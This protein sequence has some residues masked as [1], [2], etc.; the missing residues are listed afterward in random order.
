MIACA[1]QLD[2][3]FDERCDIWSLGITAIELADGQAPLGHLHSNKVLF[4]IPRRPPPTVQ[5]VSQW[6]EGFVRFIAACLVKDYEHRPRAEQLLSQQSFVTFDAFTHGRYRDLLRTCHER[7]LAL[8]LPN[9]FV[10]SD[11][12]T[13]INEDDAMNK[14]PW[15]ANISKSA[16][17]IDKENNLA[18]LTDLNQQSLIDSIRRRFNQALIYTY[19]GDVLLAINPKQFL[20]IDNFNFQLKYSRARRDLLPHI[21]AVATTVYNQM[22][23]NRQAQCIILSGESGSGEIEWPEEKEMKSRKRF[24]LGKTHAAQNLISE[25]ALLGFGEQRALEN[26]LVTMNYLLEAFG[27]AQTVLNPNSSRFGKLL[28]IFF[29]EYGTIVYVQLSEFLLEK[30]RVVLANGNRR[31]FHILYS[32]HAHF[33]QNQTNPCPALLGH[34]AFDLLRTVPTYTYLG[35]HHDPVVSC[36]PLVDLF[37]IFQELNVNEEEQTSILSI[38]TAIIH[39]GNIT[40]RATTEIDE[41]GCTIEDPSMGHV[42]AVYGLLKIDQQQFIESLC[43]S[44]LMTRGE[45]VTKLNTV[46]EGQQARD[47]MAKSLYSRLF[48][49]IIFALNRYFRTELE[50]QPKALIDMRKQS[51]RDISRDRL[52]VRPKALEDMKKNSPNDLCSVAILDLF[53]FEAFD[54]NSYEQLCINIANEQLQYFFR[55][56]TFAWEIKEYDNE[57]IAETG[58]WERS[59]TR[60]MIVVSLVDVSKFDFPNNRAILDMS[61]SKPIGLLAL[62]D[63]ESRFPQSTE[64]TLLQ[65]WRQNIVSPHFTATATSNSL[66]RK[67][68][69]RQQSISLDSHLL[70]TITHYAGQIEYSA[71]DFLE[72]NRDYVPMEILD[73]LLQSEDDLVSLLFRSSLQKTGSVIYTDHGKQ[74]RPS[75]L[76]RKSFHHSA[77]GNRTQGTVSTYFRY[78]LMELV[79]SMASTQPTFVR[80][81]VPNRFPSSVTHVTY[82]HSSYFPQ[83]F[84]FDGT[85]FDDDVVM[86]QIRYSGLLET[87]EIRR[88]GF[89]YRVLY[90]E[91]VSIY[92]CLLGFSCS[93]ETSVTE[94]QKCEAILKKFRFKEYALGKTKLFLKFYHIDQLNLA[95]KLLLNKII[96][97]QARVRMFLVRKQDRFREITVANTEYEVSVTRLQAIVRGFLVRCAH[98]K[99]ILAAVA[100]QAYFRMW[101]ERTRFRRRLLHHHTQQNQVSYFLKQIEL[102]GQHSE[103]QLTEL[104]EA[105]SASINEE[106]GKSEVP[107]CVPIIVT[108]S[109]S[110]R[111]SDIQGKRQVAV[112]C[113]YYDAVHKEFLQKRK[114]KPIDEQ[115]PV[116]NHIPA[117]TGRPSTAPAISTV[118]Q[119]PPCPPPDFFKQ[120]NNDLRIVKRQTSAP[121]TFNTTIEELNLLFAARK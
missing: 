58:N 48:D 100:I 65:K 42:E 30:T 94:K 26:R 15:I 89:S 17:L 24:F 44:S 46:A 119:A 16:D 13:T 120:T 90:G 51:K 82:D 53:G 39:L 75:T 47:A 111:S 66:S 106:N 62:L 102:F 85:Q 1:H 70:F 91:F 40:L 72:K 73:L 52:S 28:E 81:L 84:T 110:T 61:L 92:S 96:R 116:D 31:N 87:I 114:S 109:K 50:F 29:S 95:R 6:S 104:K 113:A 76:S 57:G 27:N 8:N 11:R 103:Q 35:H 115:K 107:P 68:S 21:F 63:E 43:Q 34:S 54:F 37:G 22:T 45:T 14:N 60:R 4:E 18:Q 33:S 59:M 36:F 7:Y 38:L 74:E 3:E 67:S 2:C 108:Q 97:L 78:S 19:V 121:A 117:P 12:S 88:R 93:S 77:T 20:P 98:K 5:D 55:Q 25:L 9:K 86:E 79:S 10:E 64:F 99:A 32:I 80:C 112:L 41:P 56:H 83:N 49:W 105:K 23:I 118:P 101:C 69:K 71:V